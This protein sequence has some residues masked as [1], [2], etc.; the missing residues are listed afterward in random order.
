MRDQKV[1]RSMLWLVAKSSTVWKSAWE[2]YSPLSLRPFMPEKPSWAYAVAWS[3]PKVDWRIEL[4]LA[5]ALV[6]DAAPLKPPSNGMMEKLLGVK[7]C[8]FAS[9]SIC[10]PNQP[11]PSAVPGVVTD[12][13]SPALFCCRILAAPI[14]FLMAA[15]FS[16]SGSSRSKSIACRPYLVM[17]CWYAAAVEAASEQVWPSLVPP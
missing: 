9:S 15:V 3:Q 14:S 13:Y 2:K 6:W 16:Y 12:T 4:K 11:V 17:T 8:D 1:K 5:S 10:L 7:P